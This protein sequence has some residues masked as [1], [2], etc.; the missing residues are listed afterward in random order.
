MAIFADDTSLFHSGQRYHL[1]IQN[2]INS[3]SNWCACN[4]L[5]IKTS[6]CETIVLG[7][8]KSPKLLIAIIYVP[9]KLHCKHLGVYLDPTLKFHEHISCVAKKVNKFCTLMDRVRY[10]YPMECFSS[11]YNSNAMSITI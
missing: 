6:K 3:I 1:T 2:N 4:K 10:M 9:D 11:F 5:S 7:S 8:K